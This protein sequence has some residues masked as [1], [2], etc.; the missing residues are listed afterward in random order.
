VSAREVVREVDALW[1][2]MPYPENP[3]WPA[4]REAMRSATNDEMW[5]QAME[6][7]AEWKEG[8]RELID[9]EAAR[10]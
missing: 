1:V 2:V 5:L 6:G 10:P 3:Y 8:T 7:L 4:V 9:I